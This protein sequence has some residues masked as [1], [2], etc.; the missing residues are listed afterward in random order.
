MRGRSS[1]ATA[2]YQ[3]L[4][5]LAPDHYWAM[6]NLLADMAR[7]H[8]SR[9]PEFLARRAE[10]RPN[11]FRTNVGTAAGILM[12]SDDVETASRFVR[13]AREVALPTDSTFRLT[14]SRGMGGVGTRGHAAATR[15]ISAVPPLGARR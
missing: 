14:D 7:L 13:R 5:R 11:D 12:H 4:L 6:N 1:E 15:L 2:V 9:T 3:G 10:L 8:P